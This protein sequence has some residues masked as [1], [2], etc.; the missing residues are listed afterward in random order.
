MQSRVARKQNFHFKTAE[1]PRLRDPQDWGSNSA[2]RCASRRFN[3]HTLPNR[4]LFKYSHH[5]NRHDTSTNLPPVKW[6]AQYTSCNALI[7]VHTNSPDFLHVF[8][9]Q[10]TSPTLLINF[11]RSMRNRNRRGP[12]TNQTPSI[13][14]PPQYLLVLPSRSPSNKRRLTRAFSLHGQRVSLQRMLS[15]RM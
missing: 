10:T 8:P 12:R 6:N 14:S 9:L 7:H 3:Y 2:V 5:R 15:I 11:L 1:V 4:L 13:T